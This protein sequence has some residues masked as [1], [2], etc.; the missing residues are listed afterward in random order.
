LAIDVHLAGQNSATCTRD[1][2][3]VRQ[4]LGRFIDHHQLL[5]GNYLIS[6]GKLTVVNF[7]A[8]SI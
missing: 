1:G 5:A 2:R 4:M 8:A 6:L 7:L 3:R